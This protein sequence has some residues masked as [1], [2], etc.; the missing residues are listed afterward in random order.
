M[1]PWI[2]VAYS[3]PVAAAMAVFLIYPIGQ[4]SFSDGMPLGKYLPHRQPGTGFGTRHS[5]SV[6]SD[7]VRTTSDKRRKPRCVTCLNGETPHGPPASRGTADDPVPNRNPPDRH[8]GIYMIRCVQNDWRYYG[9]SSNLSGRLA[10]HRRLL[11]RTNHPN[12]GLQTDWSTYGPEAFE[13][14]VL[15]NGPDWSKV[16]DR[17]GR[18]TELIVRDRDRAYNVLESPHGRS[19]DPCG[20][21]GRLHSPE[22]KQKMR[23]ALRGDPDD[24]PGRSVSVNG[25]IYPSLA[26]A[27]RRTSLARKTL[28]KRVND[29]TES[30]YFEVRS[31]PRMP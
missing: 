21:W 28:R 30:A 19:G 26:E 23:L 4:G 22:T 2:A 24:K 16:H 6:S 13:F 15:Y 7:V 8:P 10:S 29:P 27:S 17:R 31:E 25:T 12:V 9:E 3:A 20:F 11:T 5:R 18:E 1:R 14:T